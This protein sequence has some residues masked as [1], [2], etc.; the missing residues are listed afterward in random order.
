M[1][2]NNAHFQELLLHYSQETN[3]IERKKLEDAIWHAYGTKNT[4]LVL[5]MFGF[6]LLTRKY[7]IIH[8]LSMI[9]RMQLTVE[10]IITG[11]GGSVIK[12]E[13]DNCF[14]ILPDPL[15]AVRAA[16]TIQHA[17]ASS[18]L[19]T[20][21]ELDIQASIGID[22]GQIL[23]VNHEDIFGD[24]VNRACKMGEDIGMAEEILITK[25][26]MDL[27]PAEG[28]IQGKLIEVSIGGLST[29]AYSIIYKTNTEEEQQ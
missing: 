8:Y 3:P 6:S 11:H 10:P 12:F 21:D 22:Y 19:L 5:D 16:I 23:I 4:V 28:A 29:S 27:I 13:A 26:A 14:A 15:A 20:A 2:P 24:A 9:R 25:E 17:L 1:L 7:G 18:N